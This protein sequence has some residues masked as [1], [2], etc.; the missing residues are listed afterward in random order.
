M[1]RIH[2]KEVEFKLSKHLSH[3]EFKC[4]CNLNHCNFTIVYP[5]LLDAFES[6]RE[7]IGK[8]LIVTSGFRCQ[9]HN[10]KVG[11]LP[12]SRHT[13]GQAIDIAVPEGVS[14]MEFFKVC[15]K[16]FDF[17]DI[18]LGENFVHCHMEAK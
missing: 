15:R 4:R 12:N 6:L 7:K 16:T 13:R 14:P 9:S 3:S 2:G 18:Y 10:F 11:G 17:A 1:W 8:P 5:S